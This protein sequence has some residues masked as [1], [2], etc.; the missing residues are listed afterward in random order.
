MPGW[1]LRALVVLALAG[2]AHAGEVRR[3]VLE[4][5]G[6]NCALCPVTVRKALERVPGVVEAKVDFDRKT[7]EARYDADKAKPEDL[8][9]AVSEAGFPARV[10]KP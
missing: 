2:A 6:M 8:A 5:E 10:R 7:A 1:P 3:V 4:V 9:R